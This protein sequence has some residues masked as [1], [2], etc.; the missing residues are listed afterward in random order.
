MASYPPQFDDAFRLD[1]KTRFALLRFD[2][3]RRRL[4]II[5]A[6]MIG[7]ATFF[8][9]MFTIMLLDYLFFMNDPLR[10]LLSL[11]GYTT[12]ILVVWYTG[13]NRFAS[14][15]L[16]QLARQLE[17]FDPRV[18]E[19]LLSAVELAD[20][21]QSNGSKQFVDVLQASVAKRVAAVDM[22]RLLP[23][24]LIHR[25]GLRSQWFAWSFP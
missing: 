17:A 10:W 22:R 1:P 5:R 3:R 25:R 23:I 15:D 24:G 16:P 6:A 19:D 11:L 7:I 13:M 20:P 9:C 4:L 18:R 12:T 14:R 2:Q 21:H 8:A